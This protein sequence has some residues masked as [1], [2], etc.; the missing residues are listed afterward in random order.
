MLSQSTVVIIRI[1]KKLIKAVHD[2]LDITKFWNMQLGGDAPIVLRVANK[3]TEASGLHQL[4]TNYSTQMNERSEGNIFK[5]QNVRKATVT[6]QGILRF[7]MCYYY[8]VSF[9]K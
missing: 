4:A 2:E 1:L 5:L 7:C 3:V 8:I 9:H 6:K